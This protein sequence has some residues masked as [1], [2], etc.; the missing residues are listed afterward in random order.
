MN[1]L[2][3]SIIAVR[4]SVIPAMRLMEHGSQTY[5]E[6][7]DEL[8]NQAKKQHETNLS[9]NHTLNTKQAELLIYKKFIERITLVHGGYPELN[10]TKIVADA[11]DTLK[12]GESVDEE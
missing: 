1:R 3:E 10:G 4:D 6:I 5:I 2:F 7:V 12:R 11:Y 8:I 9:L